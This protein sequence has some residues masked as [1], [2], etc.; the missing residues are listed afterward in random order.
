MSIIVPLGRHCIICI[1]DVIG[2][3]EW[4][5]SQRCRANLEFSVLY[6]KLWK[7]SRY[8]VRNDLP[9]C[10][11]YI[12]LQSGHVRRYTPDCSNESSSDGFFL[13]RSNCS[14]VFRVRYV[15][16]MFVFL[17]SFVMKRVSF[18]VYVNTANRC[19]LFCN[20]V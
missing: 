17:N 1:T 5:L 3:N 7:C 14:I 2:P 13:G 11:I 19:G 6:L 16:L 15:T 10:P 9:V 20:G 8:R 18:P 12:I 4:L